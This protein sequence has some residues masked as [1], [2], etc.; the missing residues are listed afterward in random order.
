MAIFVQ[1]SSRSLGDL[2]PRSF[3]PRHIDDV[4]NGAALIHV[5][6]AAS[7]TDSIYLN[8]LLAGEVAHL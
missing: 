3:F 8:I 4:A 1:M 7:D 2:A 5:P 6:P